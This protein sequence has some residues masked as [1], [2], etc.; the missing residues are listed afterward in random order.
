MGVVRQLYQLQEVDLEL[1]SNDQALARVASQ[2]G[3][4][5]TVATARKE[6]AREQRRLEEVRQQQHSV[7]WEIDD[8]TAKLAVLEEK[9]YS[10]RVT[11]PKEL[12]SLQREVD[13]M[14][15]RRSQVEDRV[16]EMMEQ[17]SDGET[18]VATLSSELE[19]LEAEWHRGQ[20]QLLTDSERHKAVI[21]D[22]Q[23]RRQLLLSSIDPAAV[24][25]YQEVRRQKG[26]AVVNVERGTCRGCGI[27]LSTAQL[28]QAR[29]NHLVRCS[30]CGRILFH[31]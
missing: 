9:L 25:V 22:L 12:A 15:N 5:Q 10:G 23:Q 30:N 21:A 2:L 4:S 16:L 13:G 3:E 18:R 26:R 20:Q 11:N 14:R 17:V 24:G 28:Q 31:T 7:E 29:A 19:R 27:T 6:L 1:E 8:F